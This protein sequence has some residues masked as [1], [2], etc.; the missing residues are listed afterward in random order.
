MTIHFA[1][2]PDPNRRQVACSADHNGAET[3][4]RTTSTRLCDCG[5]CRRTRR[6]RE[7]CIEDGHREG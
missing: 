3:R 7:A 4:W 5:N 6:F 2:S 1:L